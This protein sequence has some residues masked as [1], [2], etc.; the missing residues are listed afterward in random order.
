MGFK[1]PELK[2][3]SREPLAPGEWEMEVS[4][5][6]SGVSSQK[7]TPFVQVIFKVTDEEAVDTSGE[8][9]KRPF[10][11]DKFYLTEKAMF[12]IHNF[13]SAAG[14]DLDEV[15]D[16]FDSIKEYAVALTDAFKGAEAVVTT[17]LRDYEDSKTG[18]TK[19][20]AEAV[21]DGVEF[22]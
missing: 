9:Y 1:V 7:K 5:F 18:E 8:E 4:K 10:Y 6:V 16:E 17:D 20:V 22:S 19:Y 13:A 14:V 11:G 21:D 15:G 3:N 12:R 2:A